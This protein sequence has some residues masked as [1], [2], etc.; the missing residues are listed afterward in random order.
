MKQR[1]LFYKEEAIQRLKKGVDT[2]ANMV[3]VTLGPKGNNVIIERASGVSLIT[4]DGVTV[5]KEIYLEDPVE[6]MGAQLLKEAASKTNETAGD[7]TTTATVLAQA[8]ISEGIKNVVAG[9]NLIDLKRGIDIG[10]REV[11]DEL[12][13]ISKDISSNEEIINVASI[14]ANND[15]EVGNYIAEAI[16]KA[17]DEGIIIVEDSK[18]I[19]TTIDVVEGMQFDRGYISGGFINKKQT[20]E[21]QLKNVYVLIC[22]DS[23]TQLPSL[24]AIMEFVHR[25]N[26]S[27][28][29][30]ADE[31]SEEVSKTLLINHIK[32]VINCCG[33]ISPGHGDRRS[34]LL[35]DIA[36]FTNG[37]VLGKDIPLS[38]ANTSYLGY[39]KK[40][41]ISKN[42]TIIV[43]GNGQEEKIQERV[44]QI[45]FSINN[46]SVDFDI[47]RLQE[48]L[49]KL[50]GGIVVLRVGAITESELQEKKMR[51]EDALHA[52]RAALEEGV[53]PGGGVSFIRA[54]R[55]LKQLD[56]FTYKKGNIQD[57]KTGVNIV[58]KAL[59]V[60]LLSICSNAGLTG[61]V[62]LQ[63]VEKNDNTAFGYD[64]LNE[65][66]GDLFSLGVIDPLK[67]VRLSLENASSIAGMFLT[68][69]GVI[70]QSQKERDYI[71][72]IVTQSMK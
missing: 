15:Y 54:R 57:Q 9:A 42:K 67:V 26:K 72:G 53:V 6:N 38:Q 14:S 21:V 34:D 3:K 61:E 56:T 45:R 49:G 11:I 35:E 39:A 55:R 7:G 20:M 47:Q 50:T 58:Y 68:T 29:V 23:L 69:Q 19:D 27:L 44:E 52:T 32:G 28:L 36:V 64:A 18:G 46:T 12:K 71:D 4:K 2:L 40:V 31:F 43:E 24:A 30:I 25:Q 48:R 70:S 37:T 59:E 5:A 10:V 63:E 13:T 16:E 1:D 66:Y 8:I 60:P 33:V 62:I 17:G 65:E 22:N 41:I 51:I